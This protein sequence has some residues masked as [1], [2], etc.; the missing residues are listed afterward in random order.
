MASSACNGQQQRSAAVAAKQCTA[1]QQTTISRTIWSGKHQGD[2][3]Q[4]C[5]AMT[6]RT[7]GN[8]CGDQVIVCIRARW[9]GA[10][11]GDAQRPGSGQPPRWDQTHSPR[12][13]PVALRTINQPCRAIQA[14]H[15]P[16]R[17][18]SAMP[19]SQ[20]RHRTPC[21]HR[22]HSER[23]VQSAAKLDSFPASAQ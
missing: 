17:T 21:H 14:K 13:L 4:N 23:G 5:T 11:P 22:T 18:R 19:T 8:A 16:C 2:H 6:R 9:L 20:G 12:I 7:R 10:C 1:W 3:L 15:P